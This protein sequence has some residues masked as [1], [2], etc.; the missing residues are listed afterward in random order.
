[1][2]SSQSW[3]IPAY[4]SI[5][6]G[7]EEVAHEPAILMLNNGE[8]LRGSLT[9][10]LL[11][12]SSIEFLPN[13]GQMNIGFPLDMIL[14]LRLTR[15]I[16]LIRKKIPNLGEVAEAEAERQSFNI[17]LNSGHIL[18]GE[19]MGFSA[20]SAGIFLFIPVRDNVVQRSFIPESAIKTRQIGQPIGEILAK[21]TD[22]QP[23]QV[24]KGLAKQLELRDQKLGDCLTD[25]QVIS[26]ESLSVA[27]E[28][29]R[30]MPMLRLGEALQQLNMINGEQLSQALVLQKENRK[31]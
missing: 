26:M 31:K 17:E 19:T 28:R 24:E 4:F 5:A 23:D 13:R 21:I 14:E 22:I 20:H 27:L 8:C 9:R 16:P 11:E 12:H 1:M 15:P 25:S 2:K 3:P 7:T 30:S 6:E 10:L 29:Q 18:Q